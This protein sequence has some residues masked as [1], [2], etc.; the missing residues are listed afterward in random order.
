MGEGFNF[1]DAVKG[2][3]IPNQYIPAVEKGVREQCEKGIISGNHV[4][5][6][7]VEVYFG[8]YHA[9][10]SSEMAFKMAGILAFHAAPRR[11]SR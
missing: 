8:S 11:R 7:E 5:D 3:V 2:G 10:D 1:V 9:V 6:V 4:V